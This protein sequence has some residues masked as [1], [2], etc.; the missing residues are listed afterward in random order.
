MVNMDEWGRDP[1]V[2][3]MRKVFK[4]MEISQVAFLKRLDIWP[5]DLRVR[6]WRERALIMFERIWGV[7]VR[8]GIN[9][10]EERAASVYV[11]CLSRVM[12]SDG[13]DVPEELLPDIHEMEEI[14]KE[15]F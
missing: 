6:R 11:Y 14:L 8:K 10:N 3:N 4:G 2:V 15:V 12:N 5:F 9:M 7:S 1:S 13:I